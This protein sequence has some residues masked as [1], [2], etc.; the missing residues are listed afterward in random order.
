[1][2]G[3]WVSSIETLKLQVAV[4]PAPSVAVHVTVVVPGWKTTPFRL[5][6]VAGEAPLLAE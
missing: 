4:F 6:P 2:V 5:V 3:S 1:M